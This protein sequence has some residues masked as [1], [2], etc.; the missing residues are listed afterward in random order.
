MLFV[1]LKGPGV[2][3]DGVL[4]TACA[5]HVG[6]KSQLQCLITSLGEAIDDSASN[7]DVLVH[8]VSGPPPSAIDQRLVELSGQLKLAKPCC[9]AFGPVI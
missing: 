1:W 9:H 2:V 3:A 6:A 4:R 7:R 8:K 5:G